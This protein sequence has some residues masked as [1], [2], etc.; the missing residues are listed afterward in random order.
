[1]NGDIPDVEVY[2]D[3]DIRKIID[4]YKKNR[5]RDKLRYEKRKTDLKYM[6]QNRQRSKAHYIKFKE[7]K[8]NKYENNKDYRRHRSLFNYYRL[9]S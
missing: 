3:E 8:K 5:T 1:M 7:V 4:L 6:E 2:S 9:G